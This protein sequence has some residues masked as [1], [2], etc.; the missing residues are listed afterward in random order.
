MNLQIIKKEHIGN[1]MD[2]VEFPWGPLLFGGDRITNV[3]YFVLCMEG[4][5]VMGIAS[6]SPI[7]DGGSRDREEDY[8]PEIIGLWVKPSHRNKGIGSKILVRAIEY[9]NKTYGIMPLM[10]PVTPEGEA[11][12][13]KL[14]GE[15]D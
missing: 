13:K 1:V 15:G 11:V 3:N 8:I 12:V 14:R 2:V 5:D 10:I 7:R 9:V 4:A 6:I